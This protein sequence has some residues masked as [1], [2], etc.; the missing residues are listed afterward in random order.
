M[1]GSSEFQTFVVEINS[2]FEH[3]AVEK[4]KGEE[5]A[6][7]DEDTA[8][9]VIGRGVLTSGG[10]GRAARVASCPFVARGRAL[11]KPVAAW[12]ESVSKRSP[13]KNSSLSLDRAGK[14]VSS[15][16]KSLFPSTVPPSG[17]SK[18]RSREEATFLRRFYGFRFLDGED[19]TRPFVTWPPPGQ[20]GSGNTPLSCSIFIEWKPS[21]DTRVNL[22]DCAW[23][24]G[25]NLFLSSS[26]LSN[27]EDFFKILLLRFLFYSYP[28]GF[29][30]WFKFDSWKNATVNSKQIR[31][32]EYYLNN[33]FR[34]I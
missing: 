8:S 3:E 4:K 26:F 2:D 33:I 7:N 27:A 30:K 22:A 15:A 12:N 31:P 16:S 6:G 5:T 28:C 10:G 18:W 20:K 21:H 13:P 11:W 19:S 25:N 9:T 23:S 34:I 32:G 17:G 24:N 29:G 1:E 14:T